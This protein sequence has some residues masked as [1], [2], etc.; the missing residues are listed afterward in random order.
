[1]VSGTRY[2]YVKQTDAVSHTFYL[3]GAQLETAAT[4]SLYRNGKVALG[5]SLLVNGGQSAASSANSALQVNALQNGSGLTIFGS[6]DLNIFQTA[7]E[8]K[9]ANGQVSLFNVSDA[10]SVTSVT[11]GSSFFDSAAMKVTSNDVGAPALDLHAA[12]GQTAD[13]FRIYDGVSPTPNQ[14]FGVGSAGS[15]TVQN[16]A[17]TKALRLRTSGTYTDFEAGGSDLWISTNAADT[18]DSTQVVLLRGITS[19]RSLMVGPTAG[20]TPTILVLSDKNDS[21]TDPTGQIGAMYYNSSSDKFR[22]YENT[23]WRNCV[24]GAQS[25]GSTGAG[26]GSPTDTTSS[27]YVNMPGTSSLTFTKAAASTK[28]TVMVTQ[29]SFIV[30]AANN[31]LGVGVRIDSTDYDCGKLFINTL[32][33]HVQLACS[34]VI[35]SVPA[36]SQTIQLRMKRISGTGGIRM[37]TNDWITISVLETD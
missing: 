8:V 7:L 27:T 22:C 15:V 21:S 29:T 37:D 17:N 24:S 12:T 14:L 13:I 32:N 4:A 5:G 25:N 36:G 31:V 2:V 30:T 3:D 28:L 16:V 33:V 9:S 1:S 10:A 34:V 18:F 19:T 20:S 6:G 11:G 26:P 35:P 23:E